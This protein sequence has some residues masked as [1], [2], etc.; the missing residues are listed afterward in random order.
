MSSRSAAIFRSKSIFSQ[1]RTLQVSC[2]CLEYDNSNKSSDAKDKLA[3]LLQDIKNAK[4]KKDENEA[5]KGKL[6]WIK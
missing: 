2:R 5:P 4:A 3:Q 1:I 6:C